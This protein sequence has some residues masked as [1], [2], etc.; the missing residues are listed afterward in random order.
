MN[1]I[2]T[3]QL[4]NYKDLPFPLLIG[5]IVDR[6]F[7]PLVASKGFS[8]LTRTHRIDSTTFYSLINESDIFNVKNALLTSAQTNSEQRIFFRM[9]TIEGF[10]SFLGIITYQKIWGEQVI[11]I[12]MFDFKKNNPSVETDSL[13][14]EYLINNFE[15]SLENHSVELYY[16]PIFDT[17][18]MQVTTIEVVS[19]WHD[20]VFGLLRPK[21]YLD[22]LE[23]SHLVTQLDLYVLEKSCK[24]FDEWRQKYNITVPL[25]VN[26]SVA[27][28][29]TQNFMKIVNS[30]LQ[31]YKIPHEFINFQLS[32]TRSYSHELSIKE[33]AKL[34]HENGYPVWV[35]HFGSKNGNLGLLQNTAID[36]IQI[37]IKR[38]SQADDT[39]KIIVSR[40]IDITKRLNLRCIVQGVENK[41]QLDLLKEIGATTIQGNY[42]VPACKLSVLKNTLKEKNYQLED[43][44]TRTLFRQI[45]RVNVLD[46]SSNFFGSDVKSINTQTPFAIFLVNNGKP[47]TIYQNPAFKTWTKDKLHTNSED[48]DLRLSSR[49]DTAYAP[50][51][52]AIN[53]LNKIGEI[54]EC[55][56]SFSDYSCRLRIQ[57]IACEDGQKAYLL[58]LGNY[59]EYDKTQADLKDKVY[60]YTDKNSVNNS[61]IW[62]SLMY[63][64]TLSFFWK[65]THRRFLG[66]NQ[67][68]L[69]YYGLN[70][71]DIIGKTDDDLNFNVEKEK[72]VDNESQVINQGIS[73]QGQIGT[74][75]IGNQKL[76][77]IIAFKSPVYKDGK[78]VGLLGTFFD[79]TSVEDRLDELEKEASFDSLTNLK[80]RRRLNSEMPYLAH[81]KLDVMMIDVDHFKDFNDKFG[82]NYGDE[83]LRQIG[84][85]LLSNYGLGNCYRYGGDE[86]LVIRK[87]TSPEELFKRDQ[88]VRNNLKNIKIVDLNLS[89]T[90]S[91]GYVYGTPESDEEIPAMIRAADANLYKAKA[92]G[93]NC[94]IGS[95]YS[96]EETVNK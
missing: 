49:Q 77:K 45:D 9:K 96:A 19:R 12:N 92:K 70:L 74:T 48:F 35:T 37:D 8:E 15:S 71:S 44:S 20:R 47:H 82:H 66:A 94:I 39:F 1:V 89:I 59:S 26:V 10:R 55:L 93:R 16:Q 27:D 73:V 57:L 7:E 63:S 84:D 34:L 32:D 61:Y 68:F 86:F 3:A 80:N 22:A 76:R 29:S 65:D 81:H 6:N 64:S 60:E 56:L 38:L 21:Q 62:N 69:N 30:I 51:W 41:V 2:L 67:R 52:D 54:S 83:V 53:S 91:A 11:F 4:K 43:S 42:I 87:Y 24:T 50:I 25:A 23:R 85:Q 46:S 90:L 36:G 78:I 18:N 58:R 33:A 5:R 28:F 13:S 75:I 88:K 95:N 79:I 17:F 14:D 72:F 31:N 40:M